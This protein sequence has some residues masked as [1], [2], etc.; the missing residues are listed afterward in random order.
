[1]ADV[2]NSDSFTISHPSLCVCVCVSVGVCQWV[3]EEVGG[4][5]RALFLLIGDSFFS[6]LLSAVLRSSSAGADRLRRSYPL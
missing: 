3:V 6:R 5:G 2:I 4:R 1:M